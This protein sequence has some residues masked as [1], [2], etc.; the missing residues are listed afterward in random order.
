MNKKKE[1]I[2]KAYSKEGRQE[3][4]KLFDDRGFF[5]CPKLVRLLNR[6]LI[7]ANTNPNDIIL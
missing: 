7:L 2:A 3:L 4:K 1:A 5:D 6:L